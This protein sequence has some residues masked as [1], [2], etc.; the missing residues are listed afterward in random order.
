[1]NKTHH[2]VEKP[3]SVGIVGCGWLG[4]GLAAS[5]QAEKISVLATSSKTE[6][7]AILNQQSIIAQK[8]VL[9]ADITTL[10]N[11]TFPENHVASDKA[12]KSTKRKLPKL[13]A[14]KDA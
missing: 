5:L 11:T 3:L 8:L 2:H 1:M 13:E 9:P 4:K 6:N 14:H 7:V 10:D 12:T